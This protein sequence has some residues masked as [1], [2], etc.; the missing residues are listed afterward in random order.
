VTATAQRKSLLTATLGFALLEGYGAQL[1]ATR[2]LSTK[3][4]MQSDIENIELPP[5][6]QKTL[7]E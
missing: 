5:M 2:H 1:A 4:R 7:T 6:T 3:R